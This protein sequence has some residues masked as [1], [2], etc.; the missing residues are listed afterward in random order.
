MKYLIRNTLLCQFCRVT[1]RQ[2]GKLHIRE[3]RPYDVEQLKALPF[4]KFERRLEWLPWLEHSM[5]H[6][7]GKLM[8]REVCQHGRTGQPIFTSSFARGIPVQLISFKYST[9]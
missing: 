8:I 1:G 2:E 9:G 7:M 6:D 4:V 3:L 5:A